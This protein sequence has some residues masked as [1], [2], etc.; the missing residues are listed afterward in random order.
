M[1]GKSRNSNTT[2]CGDVRI[3]KQT[4]FACEGPIQKLR[5]PSGRWGASLSSA[6]TSLTLDACLEFSRDRYSFVLLP[7]G[8]LIRCRRTNSD[9]LT[10]ALY[11]VKT[12]ASRR[13]DSS[14]S[15]T[16]SSTR[17]R[18]QAVLDTTISVLCRTESL[19]R[20][21]GERA[22]ASR[23]NRQLPVSLT[24]SPCQKQVMLKVLAVVIIF[25]FRDSILVPNQK[26]ITPG[27]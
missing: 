15:S 11:L 7:S 3:T 2:P 26:F 10:F 12:T 4:G 6:L 13:V 1:A 27:D 19:L 18:P 17:S 24:L 25:H 5:H 8:L 16:C 20:A 21:R 22:D 14:V 23:I 9:W